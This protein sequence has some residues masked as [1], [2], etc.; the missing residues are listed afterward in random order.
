MH[1]TPKVG[2]SK[3]PQRTATDPPLLMWQALQVN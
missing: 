1:T 3:D 2:A